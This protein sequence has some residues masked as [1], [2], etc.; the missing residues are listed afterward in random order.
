MERA[1]RRSV[2]RAAVKVLAEA[3]RPGDRISAVAFDRTPRLL[4][5]GV[6]D[7][8]GASLAESVG[9]L[10]ASGATHLEGG[11][12]MAY[13]VARKHYLG[14]AVNR[15]VLLTDGAANL[16]EVLPD[17]LRST[18]E[19]HRKLGIALDCFGIGAE[20]LN[21]A[22]LEALSRNGDG[23]YGFLNSVRDVEAGFSRKLAGALRVAAA[24][25][26]VQVVFNP[27]RVDAYRQI[28]YRRHQLARE[29]FRDNSVD[30]AEIGGEESGNALYLI[31]PKAGGR[32]PIATVRVR[33]RDPGSGEVRELSWTV[34]PTG[35]AQPL[36]EA[37]AS[38][39]LATAAA[40]FAEWLSGS[41][42][43][44]AITPRRVLENFQGVPESFPLDEEPVR[45]REMI[46]RA[47]SIVGGKR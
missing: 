39:R 20:G 24:D 22:M 3:L 44:E 34:A 18:V 7:N 10:S 6:K 40:M 47:A 30:A 46:E 5:D 35:E 4:L 8:F 19:E 26:K 23:R 16:G 37:G 36:R 15:V 11:L 38:M 14:E 21:D 45:L 28:G 33:F 2:V 31:S 42:Y 9:T 13:E 17:T 25:V 41:G 29:D 12:E 1:D 27:A 32:G 43:A